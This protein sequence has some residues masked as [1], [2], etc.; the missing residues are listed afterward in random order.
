MNKNNYLTD[1]LCILAAVAEECR[2]AEMLKA[3]LTRSKPPQPPA[4]KRKISAL[5]EHG[6]AWTYQDNSLL[7][8]AYECWKNDDQ[9]PEIQNWK[10]SKLPDRSFPYYAFKKHFSDRRTLVGVRKHFFKLK[11][12]NCENSTRNSAQKRQLQTN[13]TKISIPKTVWKR[14]IFSEDQGNDDDDEKFEEDE[15]D[16]ILQSVVDQSSDE[17]KSNEEQLFLQLSNNAL[18]RRKRMRMMPQRKTSNE[19]E[20]QKIIQS[21]R[22]AVLN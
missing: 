3:S 9:H 8:Q 2:L 21:A 12:K 5:S 20:F 15:E 22:E 16:T 10:K 18:I 7:W 14:E 4:C 13:S 1:P 11:Q 19:V 6:S 17:E